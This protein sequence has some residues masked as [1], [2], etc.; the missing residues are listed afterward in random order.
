MF[1]R[2]LLLL[3]GRLGRNAPSWRESH[4]PMRQ[5]PKWSA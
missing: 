2:L 4:S 5:V 1:K 3:T